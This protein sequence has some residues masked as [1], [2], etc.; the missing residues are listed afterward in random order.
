MYRFPLSF[1]IILFIFCAILVFVTG[2]S[3]TQN[4]D[5]VRKLNF[6]FH[7]GF[8]DVRFFSLFQL[9]VLYICWFFINNNNVSFSFGG[10]KAKVFLL[11]TIIHFLL[12]MFNPNNDTPGSV[13][14][15]PLFTDLSHYI[16]IILIYT[17]LFMRPVV[18]MAFLRTIIPM[19]LSLSI[20]RVIILLILYPLGIGEYYYLHGRYSIL[21]EEDTLLIFSLLSIVLLLL[22]Y[23][24]KD[25]RKFIFLWLLFLIIQLLSFRRTGLLFTLIANFLLMSVYYMILTKRKTKF[26]VYSTIVIMIIFFLSNTNFDFLSGNAKIFANRYF[27]A[28]F[29]LGSADESHADYA[30]NEHIEQAFYGWELARQKLTFWGAGYGARESLFTYK[31][32]TGIHN[33]YVQVWMRFGLF[34]LAYYLFLIGIVINETIK[35]AKEFVNKSKYSILYL[36]SK[37][38]VLI[39]LTLFF[40]TAWIMISQNFTDI[41]AMFIRI[42]L[43][44]LLLKIDTTNYAILFSRK[45]NKR[46]SK[47]EELTKINKAY[48]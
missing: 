17:F 38:I 6:L 21:M 9:F 25:K 27:G 10:L 30:R 3:V 13:F 43:F 16:Y 35:L 34:S 26:I 36:L 4:P 8:I 29:D 46:E 48:L 2:H 12:I 42:I 23:I 47:E 45:Q 14:G 20:L 1:K 28:F 22:V 40:I 5:F 18:F 31:G 19:V 32:N 37:S 44:A 33:A 39:Y 15:M 11:L 7:R 24:R 41:R